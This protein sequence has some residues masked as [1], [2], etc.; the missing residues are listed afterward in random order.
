MRKN[1]VVFAGLVL[2]VAA[3]FALGCKP[4]KYIKYV[5]EAKDASFQVPWGWN[6]YF[7][8]QGSKFY[9]YNFVGP[10]DPEFFLGLPS[11]SVRWHSFGR[12]RRLR[13]GSY[14]RFRSADNY[15]GKTLRKVYGP[16]Y[17]VPGGIKR[18]SVAGWEG[19]SFVVESVAKVPEDYHFGVSI[20]PDT[21]SQGIIRKHSYVVLPMDNGFYVMVYPATRGGHMKHLRAFNHLVNTF[22]VRTDGPGGPRIR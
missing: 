18:V 20:D 4:P 21:G 6:I 7:D 2:V 13:D 9:Q 22:K 11:L 15:I 8:D 10:F 16:E 14:E 12:S 3:V 5:S 17:Q 19:K 1:G